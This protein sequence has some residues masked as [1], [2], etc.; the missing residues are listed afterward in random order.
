MD[1]YTIKLNLMPSDILLVH[2]LM[3][4]VSLLIIE[5]SLI[6]YLSKIKNI[7]L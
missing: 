5:G 6:L 4:I 2:D 1:L 7:L 3:E